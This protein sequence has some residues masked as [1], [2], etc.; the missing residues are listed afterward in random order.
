MGYSCKCKKIEIKIDSGY[1]AQ[2]STLSSTGP[3]GP[4]GP[5]GANGANGEQGLAGPTGPAGPAGLAGDTGPAGPAGLAGLN[6]NTGPA[7]LAGNTGP[8]GNTGLNGDTGP[9]GLAGLNGD[10][11]PAGP[12]GAT[13]MI[14]PTGSNSG[15]TGPTGPQGPLGPTGSSSGLTLTQ[16]DDKTTEAISTYRFY[17][18]INQL[19][20]FDSTR[21]TNSSIVY[22]ETFP[23]QVIANGSLVYVKDIAANPR[24]YTLYSGYPYE[25]APGNMR[26]GGT[27]YASDINYHNYQWIYFNGKWWLLNR[28]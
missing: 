24:I 8:T 17:P 7:G 21:S 18:Q 27:S 16:L 4:A 2:N 14:G 9:T 28:F 11:G 12:V 5:A 13:G 25:V 19:F 22:I 3:T 15:F 26:N 6:G 10:T 23:N 1:N 20:V